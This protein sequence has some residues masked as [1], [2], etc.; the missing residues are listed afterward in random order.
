MKGLIMNESLVC[1]IRIPAGIKTDTVIN[2]FRILGFEVRKV[3]SL[4]DRTSIFE[5]TSEPKTR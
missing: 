5:V 1:E 4:V 2:P 3:G